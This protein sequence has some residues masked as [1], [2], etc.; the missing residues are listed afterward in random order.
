M[1]EEKMPVKAK[2]PGKI[3]HDK[4]LAD[5]LKMGPDRSLKRL[6]TRYCD[7]MAAPPALVTIESWSQHFA[8]VAKAKAFD[9]RLATHLQERVADAALDETWNHVKNLTALAQKSVQKALDG[10]E[11]DTMKAN[12]PYD[13]AA[14]TNTATVAIKALELISGQGGNRIEEDPNFID[15]KKYA[16]EWL[17]ERLEKGD[18][19]KKELQELRAMKQ[20]MEAIVG[21]SDETEVPADAIRH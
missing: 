11:D 4:G 15:S 3:K 14:L 18:E 19:E 7:T 6:W 17:K 9:E 8:W 1:S 5:Y 20:R 10:L 12:T 13:I 21:S 16:P 2:Q